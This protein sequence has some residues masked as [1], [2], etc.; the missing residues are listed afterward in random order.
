VG[1]CIAAVDCGSDKDSIHDRDL[2]SISLLHRLAQSSSDECVDN[3]SWLDLNM[4]E[5]FVHLDRTVTTP[6]V[7]VLY[8]ML[9]RPLR[10]KHLLQE[11]SRL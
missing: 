5:L 1:P 10:D 6:G 8:D 9:R 7:S 2:S 11:R 3:S 4:D